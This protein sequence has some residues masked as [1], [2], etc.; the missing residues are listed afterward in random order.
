MEIL[1]GGALVGGG[2]SLVK[3]YDGI[4]M[5]LGVGAV[6]SGIYLVAKGTYIFMKDKEKN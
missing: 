1:I 2:L 3:Y 4:F 6:T 5:A